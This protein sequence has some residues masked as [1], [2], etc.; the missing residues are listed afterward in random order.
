MQEPEI[1]NAAFWREFD[2][3]DAVKEAGELRKGS[4]W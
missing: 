3:R 1:V 2:G 4:A